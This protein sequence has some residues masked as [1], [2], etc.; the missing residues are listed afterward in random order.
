MGLFGTLCGEAGC[1]SGLFDI[2]APLSEEGAVA[3]RASCDSAL[4][5][6]VCGDGGNE[7]GAGP[8]LEPQQEVGLCD[9]VSTKDRC[10][11][12]GQLQNICG[13]FGYEGVSLFIP[14]GL[15]L[16]DLLTR[17]EGPLQLASIASDGCYPHMVQVCVHAVNT[18]WDG[19]SVGS[20]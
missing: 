4:F 2:L 14:A 6:T 8:P 9:D 12:A 20:G 19:R 7:G 18:Q 15:C 11:V 10:A 5:D 1:A 3:L 16:D 13:D 17:M